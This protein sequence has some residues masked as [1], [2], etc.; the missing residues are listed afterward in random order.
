MMITVIDEAVAEVTD[1]G[2]E[3]RVTDPVLEALTVVVEEA[4][5]HA[6]EVPVATGN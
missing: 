1:L 4:E 2:A 6:A 5:D 3:A